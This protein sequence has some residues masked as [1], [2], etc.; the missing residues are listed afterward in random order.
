MIGMWKCIVCAN[1]CTQRLRSYARR[2]VALAPVLLYVLYVIIKKHLGFFLH[3][4]LRPRFTFEKDAISLFRLRT[5]RVI[6]WPFE[7][8]TR[9][10]RECFSNLSSYGAT[11]VSRA[12][13]ATNNRRGY[14][15]VG[16]Y[17]YI[18]ML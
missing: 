16:T 1:T 4:R 7:S 8:R 10:E 14:M 11:R 9:S 12:L 5:K 13:G 3:F 17:S 2:M 15:S 6:N 18:P